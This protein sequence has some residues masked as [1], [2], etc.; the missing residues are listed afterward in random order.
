[1][2]SIDVGI[3]HDNDPAVAQLGNIEATSSLAVA[4]LFRFA[5]PVPMAVIMDW[6][7]CS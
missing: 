4:I 5:D 7:S 6:I 2:R 1:V 3:G